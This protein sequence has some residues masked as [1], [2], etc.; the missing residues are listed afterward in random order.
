MAVTTVSAEP[1][2]P[3]A[4]VTV[5]PDDG[6]TNAAG[7]QIALAVGDN[8]AIAVTV[9]AA[10]GVTRRIY[11]VTVT[12]A[13]APLT[14]R[15]V[16]VPGHE[17]AGTAATLRLQFSAA[18]STSYAT[19]RDES[20]AVTH[21]EVRNAR[22]VDGRSDL[23]DIE[24]APE[25][26]A[27]VGVV[28]PETTDCAAAGAVCT[29]DG[30]PLSHRLEAT[31]A[32]PLALVP[33]VTGVPQV[34]RRLEATLDGTVPAE[35]AYAWLRDGE[36][37][38]GATGT[39]Y[40]L[41]GADADAR[42]AV[43]VSSGGR[44]ATSAATIPVWG[45]PG[46]PP[47][48]ADEEELFGTVLTVGSTDAYTLRLGGYGRLSQGRVRGAGVDGARRGR[49]VGGVRERHRRRHPGGV[50]GAR[51]G[52]RSGRRPDGGLG[53]LPRRSAG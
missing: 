47:L 52:A 38:V 18:V 19:L 43:R 3:N 24:I 20:F 34:G 23:W 37:I 36:E 42:L 25:S 32:G 51:G 30:R 15:F 49:S 50:A 35:L 11:T 41:T 40:A 16:S 7:H 13:A 10:D 46:N 17:G 26:D 39:G 53:R 29:A 22:R 9:T 33:A 48:G 5:T 31:V 6:D 28:L 45:L 4:M 2:D 14:A 27:D 44:I 8:N 12:R 21:G 1:S